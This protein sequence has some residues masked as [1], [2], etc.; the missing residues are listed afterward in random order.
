MTGEQ[1]QR[2]AAVLVILAA[3]LWW[4]EWLPAMI[5]AAFALWVILHKRFE[6]D[7]GEVLF[8]QWRRVWP[9]ATLVLIPLI[10]AGMLG[11]W[12]S[13][14]PLAIKVMPIGLN[15]LALSMIFF[16]NWWRLFAH[17]ETAWGAGKRALSFG[18][19]SLSTRVP[20]SHRLSSP[21]VPANDSVLASRAA[22]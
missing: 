11:F 12:V 7:S 13:P 20:E 4:G 21:P 10:L 1:R 22:P 9:P 5:V 15:L 6:G 2:R 16:G 14:R 8:R 19:R 3:C 18:I 17:L